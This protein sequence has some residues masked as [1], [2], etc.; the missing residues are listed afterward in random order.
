MGNLAKLQCSAVNSAVIRHDLDIRLAI[1]EAKGERGIGFPALPH[2]PSAGS[3][4]ISV[5]RKAAQENADAEEAGNENDYDERNP[6]P[7]RKSRHLHDGHENESDQNTECKQHDELGPQA[8]PAH[9]PIEK[10]NPRRGTN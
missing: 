2:D 10:H 9:A 8:Q 4:S 6:Y 7:G 3:P 1:A 5:E